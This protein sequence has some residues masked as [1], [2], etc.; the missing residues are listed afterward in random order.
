MPALRLSEQRRGKAMPK[1]LLHRLLLFFLGGGSGCARSW[2]RSFRRPEE[3]PSAR[4][5]PLPLLP[6]R[7]GASCSPRSVKP[8]P[9]GTET[10]NWGGWEGNAG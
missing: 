8:L 9:T 10:F 2:A 3:E 4:P 7:G 6:V 5:Q 1:L